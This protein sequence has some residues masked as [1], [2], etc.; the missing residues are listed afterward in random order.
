MTVVS[1]RIDFDDTYD[2]LGD[3]LEE[4]NDD[5]NDATFGGDTGGQ[6]STSE[7]V[8]RD[9]DFFGQ[10]AK[11]S[12][13]I[14]E[15]QMRY[16]RQQAP[17]R[18]M[19]SIAAS[20]PKPT[21]KPART[22]YEKYN[23][24]SSMTSLQV[25]PNL[26]GAPARPLSG[27]NTAGQST[28][29]GGPGAESSTAHHAAPARKMMSLEEVEASF[30]SQTKTSTTTPTP[31]QNQ[32]PPQQDQ[33]S[34]I[35][36]SQPQQ[37][38]QNSSIQSFIQPRHPHQ[39]HQAAEQRSQHQMQTTQPMSQTGLAT[40]NGAQAFQRPLAVSL[41]M[42]EPRENAQPRQI[43]Q[44]PRHQQAQHGPTPSMQESMQ[45]Q[46]QAQQRAASN[47]Q[48]SNFAYQ[49]GIIT[50]P[51]QLMQLSEE[52]RAAFLVED[53]KRAKRNH[54]IFLLS[55]DNGLMTPQD[56]NFI[57]RIQLQQLMTATGNAN[58][59]DPGA[60]LAEDFYYQVHSQIRGGPRENPQ[61]PLS[62]FA[63]TYLFQ[64]GGRQ[65][66]LGRRQYR[67]GD[68]HMQR[69]EQQVQR[70]VEAAKLKPKNK[71]LVI[72]GSL[73]KISFSNAKTPKPLLNIKRTESGEVTNRLS[74]TQR[75]SNSRKAH[76]EMSSS[77]R[78]TILR[79][80]EAV[81]TT[82]MKL[83][84]HERREPPQP[85]N[86]ED[87]LTSPEHIQWHQSM[88]TLIQLLW[89]ELKVMVPINPG[90]TIP[91]PFIALLS[92]PKGKKVIPRVFRLIAAEQRVTMVTIIVFHLD[93]LDVI[94]L[95]Q[96]Q[97]GESQ[98][99]IATREA[100]DLFNQAV[101]PSLIGFFT[102]AALDIV[103]G[104]VGLILERV[105]AQ[106][107]A[108]TKIGLGLLTLLLSRAEL[109]KQGGKTNNEEWE[110]WCSFYVRLFDVL[111]PTLP[112]IFPGSVNSGE[113]MDVWQFLAA[114]GINASPEQQQRLVI[115]GKYAMF[116]FIKQVIS[117]MFHR[118]RVMET[119]LQSKT[120]PADMAS[121]RLSNVN[122]FMRSIGLDVEL[123][124]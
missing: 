94:R 78:K 15:E 38:R 103:I 8:G 89:D 45:A 111:E 82:M 10:T 6:G 30:R 40:H 64:T 32:R 98:L 67:G 57:T 69:M 119:V 95:G 60:S 86:D 77:D 75:Q 46:I 79:N 84:D 115:A 93:I 9:F 62:H 124:G 88:Q 39:Y 109:V 21:S 122:L 54:K 102:E 20:P 49:S 2:G 7:P 16:S 110:L 80:I 63:Q 117:L 50:H 74:A 71:Q 92:Y 27:N 43:L 61:Q 123:L 121:Q 96:I 106:N 120:L 52:D 28:K 81:Y 25:D 34:S 108:R 68:N 58:D 59:Q 76:G 104:M 11:V 72:E 83:E 13:A 4:A 65:G 56:K 113:D 107:L 35:R 5:F 44:N 37:F 90:S 85:T 42:V 31:T 55:K 48:L 100:I 73:G 87:A 97:P 47:T 91:H 41:P 101:M 118:D 70:A 36:Q 22:G 26:W 3:R 51:Q 14:T 66:A 112:N 1:T 18:S 12:D 29:Y 23:E 114:L 17:Q 116:Y 105:N 24:P 19:T 53:A 33:V 99:P